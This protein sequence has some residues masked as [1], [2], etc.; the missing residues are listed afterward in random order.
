MKKIRNSQSGF[1][2]VELLVVM[3]IIAVLV[4]ILIYTINAARLQQRNTQRR[5][6]MNTTRAA[7]ESYYAKLKDYPADPTGG[8]VHLMLASG[9]SLNV[10]APGIDAANSEDPAGNSFRLCY[11]RRSRTQY[12]LYAVTEPT[13]TPANCPTPSSPAFAL[14]TGAEDFS[15]R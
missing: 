4:G 15:V 5:S 14:P 12:W 3:A 9:G 6:I 7:L 11:H 1:N 2:L 10:Y 8:Q 13:T